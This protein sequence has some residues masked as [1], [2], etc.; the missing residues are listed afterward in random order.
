M[1][2]AIYVRSAL[3]NEVGIKSQIEFCKNILNDEEFVVYT[4][5]G[6]SVH[7]KN[8]P[9]FQ[10][11]MKD[12]EDGN[13]GKVIVYKLDRIC[14]DLVSF[15]SFIAF[16]E[17]HNASF[18]SYQEQISTENCAMRGFEGLLF[19]LNEMEVQKHE[20]EKSFGRIRRL[21]KMRCR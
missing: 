8:I 11:M 6:Y 10:N 2:T 15:C 16:L 3:E 21:F 17:A 7:D 4:D 9:A 13:V 12:I 20:Q 19:A 18:A 14:R 5:N 1:K